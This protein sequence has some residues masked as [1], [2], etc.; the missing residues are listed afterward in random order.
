MV[1]QL[2]K[3]LEVAALRVVHH[4]VVLKIV[5]F[6]IVSANCILTLTKDSHKLQDILES[7]H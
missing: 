7:A 5:S 2:Y 3:R 1:K 4:I 6:D